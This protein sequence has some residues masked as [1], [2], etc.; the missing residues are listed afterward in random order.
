MIKG[1]GAAWYDEIGAWYDTGGWFAEIQ[2]ADMKQ[3]A[4]LIK[5]RWLQ[6]ANSR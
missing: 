1:L 5:Y 6:H 2:V 4:D 3:V